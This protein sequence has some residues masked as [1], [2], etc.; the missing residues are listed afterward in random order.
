MK[1]V[2]IGTSGYTYKHWKDIFYPKGVA[3]KDWLPFFAKEFKTVELNVSFYRSITEK[4][5]KRWYERTPDDFLF[6]VKGNRFITHIKRLKDVRDSVERVVEPALMLK[7]KLAMFLWQLPPN[8]VFNQENY[9]TVEEFLTILPKN[10]RNALE[11]RDEWWFTQE[12]A[13]LLK[14]HNI[15]MVIPNW[16]TREFPEFVTADFIYIRLHGPM[17]YLPSTIKKWAEKIKQWK[18]T[19]DVYIYFNNDAQGFA[20]TNARQLKQFLKTK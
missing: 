4:E 1:K 9:Q 13:D 18:K 12:I 7:E 14:K 10:K 6:A 8:F 11:F 5:Y 19:H 2:Y 20:L 3:Q 16:H 17:L 15:S